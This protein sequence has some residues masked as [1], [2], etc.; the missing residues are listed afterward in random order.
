MQA[1]TWALLS[2][3]CDRN[4]SQHTSRWAKSKI[5]SLFNNNTWCHKNQSYNKQSSLILIG[6]L[7][8]NNH[9][10][11]GP[12][13]Q[14][15]IFVCLSTMTWAKLYKEYYA[16]SSL[17]VRN[18]GY[19]GPVSYSTMVSCTTIVVHSRDDEEVGVAHE[20]KSPKNQPRFS[21]TTMGQYWLGKTKTKQAFRSNWNAFKKSPAEF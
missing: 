11:A 21:Q 2:P 20:V 3:K 18:E 7:G 5:N 9:A 14:C 15:I 17:Y 16:K 19:T 13:S 10:S 6:S 1:S 4:H 8:L 12:L